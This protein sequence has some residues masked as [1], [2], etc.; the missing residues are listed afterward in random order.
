MNKKKLFTGGHS[1]IVYSTDPGYVTTHNEDPEPQTIL[2]AEQPLKILLDTK[3]R[4]GKSVTLVKG[5]TGTPADLEAL[6]KKLKAH[7]G[8]GGSAKVGE[9]MVQGDNREKI[10]Q[11]CLKLGYARTKKA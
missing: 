5:F 7:C 2:P 9:I 4:A 8:T 11:Y 1:G 3:N 10:L 6:G